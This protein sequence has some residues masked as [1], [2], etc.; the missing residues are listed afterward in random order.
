MYSSIIIII[1]LFD[2]A[3]TS[4]YNPFIVIV[5]L[6]LHRFWDIVRH[7]SKSDDFNPPLFGAPV[8]RDPVV[9]SPRSFAAEN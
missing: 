7:W 4:S 6:V 1:A 2:I 5:S 3:H 8:G 9:I